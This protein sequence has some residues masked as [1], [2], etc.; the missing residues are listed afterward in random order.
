MS[1]TMFFIVI[2]GVPLVGILLGLVWAWPRND[3]GWGWKGLSVALA[4]AI[5]QVAV[6]AFI[7]A[8]GNSS[9]NLG[10]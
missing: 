2:F 1:I 3:E 5:F 4:S 7:V 6:A 9:E 10:R 8:L